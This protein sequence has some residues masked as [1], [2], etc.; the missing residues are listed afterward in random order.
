MAAERGLLAS[1]KRLA[2]SALGYTVDAYGD[3]LKDE[4]EILG[5]TADVVTEIYAVESAIARADKLLAR[6]VTDRSPVAL[7]IA[8][9][10]ASDAMD[11]IIHSARQVVAALVARGADTAGLAD[12]TARLAARPT[13]D[14]IAARRR[15]ADAVIQAGWYP[16]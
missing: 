10:Y 13:V 11:R 8:R 14:T 4:Q 6:R 1:A 12:L 16:F 9:I 7:D 2:V 3:S 15:V 5:H